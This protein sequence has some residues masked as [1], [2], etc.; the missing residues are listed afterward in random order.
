MAKDKKFKRDEHVGYSG[1][2]EVG[3]YRKGK[4]IRKLSKNAGTYALFE[5]L[6][7]CLAGTINANYDI[8]KRPGKIRLYDSSGNALLTFGV[9]FNDF[10]IKG[11][12]SIT[13]PNCSIT[14]NFLVPGATI[15]NR[16]V[17]SVK[18][19]PMDDSDPN[20][21]PYAEASFNNVIKITTTDTNI[22]VA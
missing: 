17:A 3:L 12:T 14:Y 10:E 9:S 19:F 18:L 6:C 13:N 1:S 15:L 2:V 5:Y 8:N 22:Y 21:Q 7:G 11:N 16:G 20:V 4:K